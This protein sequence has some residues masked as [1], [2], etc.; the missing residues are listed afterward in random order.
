[1]VLLGGYITPS[2][3]RMRACGY[4][5]E[6]GTERQRHTEEAPTAPLPCWLCSSLIPQPH[7][8]FIPICQQYQS[9]QYTIFSLCFMKNPHPWSVKFKTDLF[10]NSWN[11]GFSRLLFKHRQKR[12]TIKYKNSLNINSAIFPNSSH[13]SPTCKSIYTYKEYVK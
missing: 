9:L 10:Y 8:A 3:C 1:M 7:R 2:L 11:C 6:M 12:T 4:A 13:S 5:W